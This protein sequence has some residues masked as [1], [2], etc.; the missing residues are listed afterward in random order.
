MNQSKVKSSVE[1]VKFVPTE[2]HISII[3]SSGEDSDIAKMLIQQSKE[4]SK[5][6]KKKRFS[7]SLG[8]RKQDQEDGLPGS[9]NLK[10]SVNLNKRKKQKKK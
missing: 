1:I 7:F 6:G 8:G 4:K 2:D 9:R 5:F 10:I 3:V